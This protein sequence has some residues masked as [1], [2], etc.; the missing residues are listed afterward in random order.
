MAKPTGKGKERVVP[1]YC[2]CD[3]GVT[4]YKTIILNEQSKGCS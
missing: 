1:Y 2:F 4:I 3:G